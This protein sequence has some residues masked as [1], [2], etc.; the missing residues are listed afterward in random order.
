MN[1]YELNDHPRGDA[2]TC[3]SEEKG[4]NQ[5]DAA[6]CPACG[7]PV[8]LLTWLPPYRVVLKLYGK[9]FGDFVFIPGGDDFL[10]SQKFRE[11][12]VSNRL[13]GLSGFDAVEVL[14]VKTR[15]KR[16]LPPPNYFRVS[17]NYG[18]TALDLKASG[19]EW[20][21]PPKCDYCREATKI[22]WQRLIVEE[23]TWSGEDAFRPRGLSGTVMVT[24][25]F[26]DA[27]EQNG[28][29]NAFF[30]PAELAGH[31]FEPWNKG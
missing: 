12:Y 1:F 26:K 3:Y 29:T 18:Q 20:H 23:G 15:R 13:T 4:Y 8:S 28:I 5:G 25:R 11:V 19:F 24:Q 27:C 16:I 2:D 10:V 22:R 14:N 30:T 6:S 21:E 9:E 31:D 17:P 7:G